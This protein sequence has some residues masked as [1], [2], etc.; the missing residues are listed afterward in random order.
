MYLALNGI[1]LVAYC[2]YVSLTRGLEEAPQFTYIV[3]KSY[4]CTAKHLIE[5]QLTCAATLIN[6]KKQI[7]SHSTKVLSS[8]YNKINCT[9]LTK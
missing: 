6:L 1:L 8:T 2:M 9:L 5:N 4:G 7:T 3:N